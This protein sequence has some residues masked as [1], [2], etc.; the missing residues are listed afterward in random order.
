MQRLREVLSDAGLRDVRTYIQSGNVAFDSD[1]TDHETVKR[2]VAESIA[3]EFFEANVMI[4]TRDEIV[5]IVET[6][7]FSGEQF[8]ERMFHVVFLND[9]LPPDKTALLMERECETESFA[10]RGREVYCFLRA[11]VADSTIGRNFFDNKLK[12]PSTARNWRTMKAVL[13]L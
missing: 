8:D 11:G 2:L 6:N 1:E 10:V 5:R 9:E 13:E 3:R 7:P 12:T 4:R